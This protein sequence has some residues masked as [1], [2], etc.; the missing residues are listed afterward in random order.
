MDWQAIQ[1]WT[2]QPQV[3]LGLVAVVVVLAIW[4]L[5]QAWRWGRFMRRWKALMTH[6]EGGSLE[7]TLYET[8]RRVSLMEETLKAHGNHLERLQSQTN[9]CLQRVGLVRYDA[10]PD[11]GGQQSFALA[12]VDE[13]G[14]GFLL[15][16]IH[17]RQE[18]RVYAKPVQKRTSTIGL[19]EEEQRALREASQ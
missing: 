17:S 14:D 13:H 7:H 2:Q 3:T 18:M 8:L 9:R 1:G 10:F 11:A 4:N 19:S 15:S 16:G 12:V 6:S 5:V